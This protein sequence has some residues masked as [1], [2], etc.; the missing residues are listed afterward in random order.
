MR[1][2]DICILRCWWSPGVWG[3]MQRGHHIL[4]HRRAWRLWAVPKTD[5]RSYWHKPLETR[6]KRRHSKHAAIPALFRLTQKPVYISE[7]L[8][9][10]TSE[11]FF[12]KAGTRTWSLS[13][14]EM[15][16]NSVGW[17]Y[18][19]YFRSFWNTN[20]RRQCL[21]VDSGKAASTYLGKRGLKSWTPSWQ[22]KVLAPPGRAFYGKQGSSWVFLLP[23]FILDGWQ[24]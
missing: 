10:H 21:L 3:K 15:L 24:I 17:R 5:L 19:Q 2:P 6:L 22:R 12:P 16:D 4:R 23:I 20:L 9:G 14:G 13:C 11:V 1:C 8:T 18:H 7:V